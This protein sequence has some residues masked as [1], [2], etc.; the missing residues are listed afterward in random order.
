MQG[1]YKSTNTRNEYADAGVNI[2]LSA[3]LTT[4][5]PAEAEKL[6]NIE[7]ELTTASLATTPESK[8]TLACHEPKP[9]GLNTGAITE[10]V[11]PSILTDGSLMKFSEKSKLCRNHSTTLMA[12]IIVPAFSRKCDTLSQTW[13]ATFLAEGSLYGGSSITKGA[14]PLSNALFLNIRPDNMP[15]ATPI[16]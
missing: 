11:L 16:A 9:S 6:A 8:A 13:V 1:V 15:S 14:S 3:S 2:P 4:S 7:S 10:P 12:N 5:P